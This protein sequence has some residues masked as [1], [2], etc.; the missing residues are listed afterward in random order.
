MRTVVCVMPLV[1]TL[2]AP[3]VGLAD[4]VSCRLDYSTCLGEGRSVAPPGD[5]LGDCQC[6]ASTPAAY[7]DALHPG[8][9]AAE[10]A[11][12]LHV[13]AVLP[14]S[15]AAQVGMLPG[16]EI[17]LV[18]GWRP[19]GSPCGSQGWESDD[20]A[21]TSVLTLRRGGH[22]WHAAVSLVPVR[23]LLAAAWVGKSGVATPVAFGSDALGASEPESAHYSFGI[24]WQRDTGGLLIA[25]VLTGSPAYLAGMLP[26]DRI[27]AVNGSPVG[28]LSRSALSQ[29]SSVDHRVEL[30]LTV[31]RADVQRSI[32]LTSS[33][34]SAILIR[35]AARTGARAPEAPLLVSQR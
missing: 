26:G 16:D 10:T 35:A 30:N 18:N 6:V 32:A 25:A 20:V 22:E 2:L 8:L 21:R 19:G 13:S 1:I 33:G 29:L 11:G 27:I 3:Q 34:L 17:V 31:A 9:V 4:C 7:L 24:R 14:G 5:C 28:R 12:R 23:A 15:P